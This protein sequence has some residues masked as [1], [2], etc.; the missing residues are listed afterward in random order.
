M[1]SSMLTHGWALSH[2]MFICGLNHDGSSNVPALSHS[3]SGV[4]TTSLTMAEP[5]LGQNLR[6]TGSPLSPTSSEAA[7]GPPS[8]R[9]LPFGR[10]T[11]I[12]KAE[13][14]CFWQCRQWHAAVSTGSA[15]LSYRTLPH[16]HPPR[17][18]GMR[19]PPSP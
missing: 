4:A 7:K 14:V 2:H 6:K 9:R 15:S 17:M 5:H 1:V 3:R 16:R 11:K 18:F 12:E 10:T 19:S 13:L 8:I